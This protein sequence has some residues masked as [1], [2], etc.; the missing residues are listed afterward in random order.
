M[1]L[2]ANVRL[3]NTVKGETKESMKRIKDVEIYG[4]WKLARVTHNDDRLHDRSSQIE[5][6]TKP[7]A[8]VGCHNNE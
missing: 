4:E 5:H 2:A 7:P 8:P 3:V 1:G 6:T